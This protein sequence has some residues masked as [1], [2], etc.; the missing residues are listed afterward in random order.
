M[1]IKVKREKNLPLAPFFR[2]LKSVG[3]SRVSKEAA[4][5]MRDLVEDLCLEIA[6]EAWDLTLHAKRKTV[7]REDIELAAKRVLKQL[8]PLL[9]QE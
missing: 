4:E 1:V 5:T 8:K 2:I 6:G 9:L 3:A 7:M